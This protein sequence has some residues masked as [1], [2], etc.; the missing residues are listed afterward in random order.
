[1]YF[2]TYRFVILERMKIK[3]S[4]SF[5]VQEILGQKDRDMDKSLL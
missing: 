4:N 3:Q 2:Y 1:M 5:V